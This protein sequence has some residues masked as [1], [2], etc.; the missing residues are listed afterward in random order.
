MKGV[1]RRLRNT[2]AFV[3]EINKQFKF[4]EVTLNCMRKSFYMCVSCKVIAHSEE[5]KCRLLKK[6]LEYSVYQYAHIYTHNILTFRTKTGPIIRFLFRIP[7]TLSFFC[8]PGVP[9]ANARSCPW[10]WLHGGGAALKRRLPAQSAER[11]SSSS[12][13]VYRLQ[14]VD[15]VQ[16]LVRSRGGRPKLKAA[17]DCI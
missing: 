13:P 14:S 7:Q 17:K 16:S 15:S 5:N 12:P 8:F 11:G 9:L 10:C 6:L 4:I 3:L 2:G 1:L